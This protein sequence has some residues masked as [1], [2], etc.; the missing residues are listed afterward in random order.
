MGVE[1]LQA[2]WFSWSYQ[3]AQRGYSMEALIP[4]IDD[5]PLVYRSGG[6]CVYQHWKDNGWMNLW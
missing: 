5:S 1:E 4:R 6:I 3:G 2:D